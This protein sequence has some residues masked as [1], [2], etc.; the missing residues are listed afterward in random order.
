MAGMGGL[1]YSNWSNCILLYILLVLLIKN[2][3]K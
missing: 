2:W 3:K 1:A